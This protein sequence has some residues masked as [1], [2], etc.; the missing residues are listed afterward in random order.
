MRIKTLTPGVMQCKCHKVSTWHH[1]ESD[2]KG[3]ANR[4][5]AYELPK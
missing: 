2:S 3:S 4:A 1:D 5:I